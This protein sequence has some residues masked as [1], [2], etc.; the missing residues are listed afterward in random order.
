MPIVARELLHAV[1]P[2]HDRAGADAVAPLVVRDHGRRCVVAFTGELDLKRAE[3]FARALRAAVTAAAETWVDLTATTFMD[4]S[5]VHA[6]VEAD[7][8]AQRGGHRL[9][10]LLQPGPVRRVLTLTGADDLL[11]L[12][13]CEP[14]R[15][16]LRT[17]GE[18]GP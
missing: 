17:V 3:P 16:H 11:E 1:V 7:L 13:E 10:V 2:L 12:H 9:A 6:L 18:E 8:L 4:S 15:R 5:G 14:G